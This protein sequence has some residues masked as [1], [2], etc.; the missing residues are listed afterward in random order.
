MSLHRAR[1][2]LRE[3]R[4]S[5]HRSRT[6]RCR[7]GVRRAREYRVRRGE[8]RTGTESHGRALCARPALAL[9]PQ[10]LDLAPVVLEQLGRLV[11]LEP[12]R[13]VA[14]ASVGIP[15][16]HDALWVQVLD[17]VLAKERRELLELLCGQV[18]EP[19]AVPLA[20]EHEPAH[21]LVRLAEGQPA[22][23]KVVRHVRRRRKAQARLGKHLM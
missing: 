12:H 16:P 8:R 21:D 13:L 23:G 10:G 1:D 9:V 6:A 3:A 14:G 4:R 18:L 11:H 17:D 7:D 19:H 20:V 2:G 15:R 22:L 5:A